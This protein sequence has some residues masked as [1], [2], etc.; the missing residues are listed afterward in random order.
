MVELLKIKIIVGMLTS[1]KRS[2][3]LWFCLQPG[4]IQAGRAVRE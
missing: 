1:N 3:R 4:S 2:S